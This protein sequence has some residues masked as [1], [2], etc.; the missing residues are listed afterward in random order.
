VTCDVPQ[1]SK[2]S[3]LRQLMGGGGASGDALTQVCGS[4][5]WGDVCWR[6]RVHACGCGLGLVVCVDVCDLPHN[7]V[8]WRWCIE[9]SL[10]RCKEH[11]CD[12][13]MIMVIIM[14]MVMES[15]MVILVL[16]LKMRA[17]GVMM[18]NH[19]L[20]FQMNSRVKTMTW[21]L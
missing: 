6:A 15:V 8:A 11:A 5:G 7:Q 16:H 4:G 18:N 14:M 1:V 12:V 19:K 9:E 3:L 10:R 20:S 21:Y 13:V 2:R 17:T